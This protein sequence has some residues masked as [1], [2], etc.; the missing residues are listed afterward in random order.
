[1]VN[2]TPT[3]GR[4]LGGWRRHVA[5]LRRR[6]QLGH[7]L[8]QPFEMDRHTGYV[9]WL[10]VEGE[11]DFERSRVHELRV[12]MC[13]ENA[14]HLFALS[15]GDRAE[16]DLQASED[17]TRNNNT[18]NNNI[19]SVCFRQTCRIRVHVLNRNDNEP[20]LSYSG[21][22][23]SNEYNLS[24]SRPNRLLRS[25]SLF[26][27]VAEDATLVKRDDLDDQWQ[28]ASGAQVGRR[29]LRHAR[30]AQVVSRAAHRL[31]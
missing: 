30:Q 4:Q 23:S 22:S 21:S 27:L 20:K 28:A 25:M 24:L 9:R 11:L 13:I 16:L 10:S 6:R 15:P 14:R 1:M 29:R 12:R 17:P 5:L 26:E 3:N 8:P 18:N 7:S 31:L 2:A 19:N